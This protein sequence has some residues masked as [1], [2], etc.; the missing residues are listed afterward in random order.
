[1]AKKDKHTLIIVD[2]QPT[3]FSSAGNSKTLTGC[4][5]AI[6]KAIR[7]KNP[8]I[9]VEW[10]GKAHPT[11]SELTNLTDGYNRTFFV[12]KYEQ[13]GS[14]VIVEL[15]KRKKLPKKPSK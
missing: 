7:N 4:K 8:V 5:R 2:M 13:D 14:K 11:T 6:K 1:M 15:M 9:F 10:D 3:A 12:N